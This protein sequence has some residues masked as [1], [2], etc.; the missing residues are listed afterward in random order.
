MVMSKLKKE[1]SYLLAIFKKEGFSTNRTNWEHVLVAI[2]HQLA[3]VVAFGYWWWTPAWWIGAALGSGIFIGREYAQVERKILT[4]LGYKTYI[5]AEEN[6]V[7]VCDKAKSFEYWNKD[8]LLDQWLPKT[9][10]IIIASIITI[11]SM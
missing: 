4:K 9:F 3:M 1:L 8:S 2:Q 7:D 6:G 10:V 5:E 11:V